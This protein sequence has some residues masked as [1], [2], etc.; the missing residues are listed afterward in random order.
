MIG[1]ASY[2][3]PDVTDVP[4]LLP[5]S[6][7]IRIVGIFSHPDRVS[8]TLRAYISPAVNQGSTGKDTKQYIYRRG[9]QFTTKAICA[10]R[11]SSVTT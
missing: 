8:F 6:V 11:A 10:P 7:H 5:L 9:Y 2:A 3:G 4:L 1:E